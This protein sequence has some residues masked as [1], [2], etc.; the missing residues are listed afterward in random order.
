MT[1]TDSRNARV[2]L[3][4]DREIVITREFDAPR[5]LVWRAFTTPEHVRRWWHANRGEITEIS[6]DLRIGGRWRYAMDAP[7][8][9]EVAFN[10]EFLELDPEVRSVSTEAFEGMPDAAP[11][12]NT[13]TL[14][15]AGGRTTMTILVEHAL[16]EHRDAHIASGM[17]DGLQDALD[18]LEQTA[19]SMA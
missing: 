5:A 3:R 9:G 17:E 14:E 18:L 12:V 13:M 15:E 2:E 11:S 8:Y 19:R 6:I 10:G 4:G 1:L 16:P 7:G